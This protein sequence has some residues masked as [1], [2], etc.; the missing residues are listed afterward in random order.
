MKGRRKNELVSIEIFGGG[1]C[2]VLRLL[3]SLSHSCTS[4]RQGKGVEGKEG[5]EGRRSISG[6]SRISIALSP[7]FSDFCGA[8]VPTQP[9]RSIKAPIT[10]DSGRSTP[11]APVGCEKIS[12]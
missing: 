1:L 3:L 6:L 5:V 8:A 11:V 10:R 9:D 4:I 7:L 2:S 12:S